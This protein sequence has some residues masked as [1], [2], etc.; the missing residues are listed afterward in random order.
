MR[1]L[2]LIEYVAFNDLMFH[3]IYTYAYDL[4]LKLYEALAKSNFYREAV[5]KD[6]CNF[7]NKFIDVIIHSK[8]NYQ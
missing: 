6:H 2:N 3:K 7:N 4:R 5:L 1:V 8:I